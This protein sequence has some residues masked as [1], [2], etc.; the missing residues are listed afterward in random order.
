MGTITSRL[1]SED[2]DS[3]Q[4]SRHDY[5]EKQPKEHRGDFT[6]STYHVPAAYFAEESDDEILAR[7]LREQYEA[8]S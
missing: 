7:T 5:S 6:Q 2:T 3:K 1:S 4:P 8:L